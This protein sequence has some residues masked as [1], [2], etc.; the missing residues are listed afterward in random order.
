MKLLRR[1]VPNEFYATISE[2]NEECLREESINHRNK[3]T[4]Y[5]ANCSNILSKLFHHVPI[6]ILILSISWHSIW[7]VPLIAEVELLG[8]LI[9]QARAGSPD[10]PPAVV[11]PQVV[12]L[13]PVNIVPLEVVAPPEAAE[14]EGV[15]ERPRVKMEPEVLP[16]GQDVFAEVVLLGLAVDREIGSRDVVPD[17]DPGVMRSEPCF[18]S[19]HGQHKDNE[20]AKAVNSP[21]WTHLRHSWGFR[22]SLAAFITGQRFS[23]RKREELISLTKGERSDFFVRLTRIQWARS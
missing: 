2:L 18:R 5:T 3:C 11:A 9:L 15:A 13:L 6:A 12:P 14:E 4:E 17:V 20:E 21:G 1:N 19:P 7:W 16:G 10:A 22:V 8:V 23:R